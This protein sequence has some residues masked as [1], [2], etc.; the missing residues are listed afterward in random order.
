MDN[1]W[2]GCGPSNFRAGRPAGM[3][4]ELIVVHTLGGTLQEGAS[5]FHRAETPVSAHYAVGRFGEIQQFVLETDTAF[6]AGLAI[7]PAARIVRERAKTNANFYSIGIEHEG[8][9]DEPWTAAQMAASAGLI[10]EV[11]VRWNIPLDSDHVVA[12][13]AI[14]ASVQCPGGGVQLSALLQMASAQQQSHPVSGG[15]LTL[16]STVNL[17]RRAVTTAPVVKVLPKGATVAPA[18]VVEGERVSGNSLWYFDAEG[19]CFWAGATDRPNPSEGEGDIELGA[20]TDPMDRIPVAPPPPAAASEPAI[21]RA[22]FALPAGQYLPE[23]T[24]KDLIVLHFTA[25][26]SAQSAFDTWIRD[27]QRVATAYLVDGDGVIYETF[28]P[29]SWAFHLGMKKTSMHDRRSIGI[30]I[31][32]VGPLKPS[33]QD[34]NTLNWWPPG[35]FGARFCAMGETDKFVKANFRGI[36]YFAAFPTAQIHSVAA[37]VAYLC[38]RF[39]IAKSLP[40]ASKLFEFDPVFFGSYRGVATHANF[41]QDKWD[42]GPA[43]DWPALGI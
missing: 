14:R 35:N 36:D 8:K 1:Q 3:K 30:E 19:N 6:H 17:R 27:Q 42:I 12:H 16:L 28:N 5:R 13:S 4:P 38:D 40:P 9:P 22:R 2:I 11:A 26:G 15:P 33:P 24:Q 29:D 34:P 43:F 39:S 7:N 41:R 32:N 37:L 18:G 31:A 23:R 20:S 21:N 25:G 10:H